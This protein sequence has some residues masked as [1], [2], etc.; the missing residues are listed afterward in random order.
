MAAVPDIVVEGAPPKETPREQWLRLSALPISERDGTPWTAPNSL[1]T[2]AGRGSAPKVLAYDF[3]YTYKNGRRS[4]KRDKDGFPA[5]VLMR[6]SPEGGPARPF[7]AQAA[8]AYSSFASGHPYGTYREKTELEAIA[9]KS[10]NAARC[11]AADICTR[12]KNAQGARWEFPR[13]TADPGEPGGV[14]PLLAEEL[15]IWAE[16]IEDLVVFIAKNIMQFRDVL[17]VDIAFIAACATHWHVTN[18]KLSMMSDYEAPDARLDKCAGAADEEALHLLVVGLLREHVSATTIGRSMTSS[19]GEV[20]SLVTVRAPV[21]WP[22]KGSNPALEAAKV[23][24]VDDPRGLIR[25]ACLHDGYGY[26]PLS[27]RDRSNKLI[28]PA[29]TRITNATCM[30]PWVSVRV[31]CMPEGA[32]RGV[33]FS[34]SLQ[35]L[36]VVWQGR[37][38]SAADALVDASGVDMG[39]CAYKP[40]EEDTAYEKKAPAVADSAAA[41]GGGGWSGDSYDDGGGY[42]SGDFLIPEDTHGGRKPKRGREDDAASPAAGPKRGRVDRGHD[43]ASVGSR[44]MGGFD[45]EDEEL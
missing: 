34:L 25:S 7:M 31:T 13:T 26:N 23:R 43:G 2:L 42:A 33:K 38:Q 21:M 9:E 16:L 18:R 10:L 41:G 20:S 45:D 12:G 35:S 39:G 15:E 44:G 14:N 24:N 11:Y 19:V 30:A 1:R 28:D 8:P 22:R 36:Q 6:E 27:M 32:Q 5:I 40:T 37:V 29:A 3:Q 17:H 4:V